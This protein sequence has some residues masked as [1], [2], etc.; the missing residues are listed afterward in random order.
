MIVIV[1]PL[2]DELTDVVE[3]LLKV[4]VEFLFVVPS[5][6]SISVTAPT[7][8]TTVPSFCEGNVWD[9]LVRNV[10]T[11]STPPAPSL[12][13]STLNTVTESVRVS[14]VQDMVNG[15][16][17]LA[18]FKPPLLNPPVYETLPLTIPLFWFVSPPT[19]LLLNEK[20][21]T[22]LLSAVVI[23]ISLLTIT[24]F[25]FCWENEK[26]IVP[27]V[28]E[29]SVESSNA[30]IWEST[31]P[32][33]VFA[34]SPL[35]PGVPSEPSSPC[36][37]IPIDIIFDN[38]TDSLTAVIVTEPLYGDVVFVIVNVFDDEVAVIYAAELSVN[39]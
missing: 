39:E 24:S 7:N 35:T 34:L 27:G 32:I 12:P 31:L 28:A 8:D 2:I 19:L 29:L 23:V 9:S 18:P 14:F 16:L 36:L 13:P 17:V 26:L 10:V 25:K 5:N 4:Y 20:F 37:V 3:S 15:K 11:A 21:V 33:N 1:L 38:D 30:N 6:T 22:L